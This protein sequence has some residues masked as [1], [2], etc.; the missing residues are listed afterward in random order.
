M[1]NNFPNRWIQDEDEDP[2]VVIAANILLDLTDGRNADD[3][4]AE[5]RGGSGEEEEEDSQDESTGA[6]EEGSKDDSSEISSS[7]ETST[8]A[9]GPSSSTPQA[10]SNRST[11]YSK[12]A[13]SSSEAPGSILPQG[14]HWKYKNPMDIPL[15]YR[16]AADAEGGERTL[17]YPHPINFNSR[18][19][20]NRANKTRAREVYRARKRF[21][22]P[23]ARASMVGREFT[24]THFD[25]LSIAH[26]AYAMLH[27]G[28][29]IPWN[30]LTLWWRFCWRDERTEQALRAL[31][32]RTPEF[33]DLRDGYDG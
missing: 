22:L 1:S 12:S 7:S 25:W 26:E 23:L 11:T 24:T 10:P 21:H 18:E 8:P 28:R 29:L 15:G 27:N 30:I 20:V 31:H 32:S 33:R 3:V 17:I 19:S 2:E 16:T 9:P 5:M 6:P 14:D 4:R 13:Q